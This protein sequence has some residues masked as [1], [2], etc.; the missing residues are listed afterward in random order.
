MATFASFERKLQ[1]TD[2]QVLQNLQDTVVTNLKG[3]VLFLDEVPTSKKVSE[4][5]TV[6][7]DR[8]R[9]LRNF[10]LALGM[11][12]VMA[13][14]GATAANMIGLANPG[15]GTPAS[16]SRLRSADIGWM[17]I[18]FFGVPC[19]S[20]PQRTRSTWNVRGLPNSWSAKHRM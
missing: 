8:L 10:G 3:T 15:F 16:A 20:L 12:V 5:R 7:V 14:T 13:G 6:A 9:F 4:V 1:L 19:D 2:L 11:R 17:E 18:C